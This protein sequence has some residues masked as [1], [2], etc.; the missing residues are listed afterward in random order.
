MFFGLHALLQIVSVTS[1][2]CPIMP[3]DLATSD[4]AHVNNQCLNNDDCPGDYVCCWDGCGGVCRKPD[5]MKCYYDNHVFSIAET[6]KKDDCTVS[7]Q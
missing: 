1:D 7:M 2:M 3:D 5:E 6:F 4:C